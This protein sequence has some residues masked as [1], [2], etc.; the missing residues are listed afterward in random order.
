[1]IIPIKYNDIEDEFIL[2]L[3]L[4]MRLSK[5]VKNHFEL[6]YFF[7]DFAPVYLLGGGIRDLILARQPKDLDFVIVGTHHLPFVEEVLNKFKIE[8]KLNKFGGYKFEYKDVYN[9]NEIKID[10]WLTDDLFS[11]IQFN[12]DGLFFDMRTMQL[13]SFTFN[14]FIQNGLR[15]VNP[16][17]NDITAKKERI[18]KL[19]KF[20]EEFRNL[21]KNT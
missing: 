12:V 2:D 11:A 18:R 1:M 3:S 17:N 13:V 19:T 6:A 5:Y 21:Q 14:D 7:A 20:D 8:Y 4:Q 9:G 15:E 16:E 10:L